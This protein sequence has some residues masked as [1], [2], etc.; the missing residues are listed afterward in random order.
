MFMWTDSSGNKGK[1]L[2]MHPCMHTLCCGKTFIRCYFKMVGIWVSLSLLLKMILTRN[3][4]HI[5]LAISNMALSYLY[6]YFLR[7]YLK[8]HEQQR[9]IL[10]L[11]FSLRMLLRIL[12]PLDMFQRSHTIFLLGL[13]A[14]NSFS[15]P[16]EFVFSSNGEYK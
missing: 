11:R 2:D 14:R 4:S 10:M 7:F 1:S 6:W 13:S 8:Y 15:Y 9:E 5:V 16:W 3:L 12:L